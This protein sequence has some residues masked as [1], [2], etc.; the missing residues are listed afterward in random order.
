M[1]SVIVLGVLITLAIILLVLLLLA[2]A[3]LWW[4]HKRSQLQFIEPPSDDN[5]SISGSLRLVLDNK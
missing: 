1:V 2:G 3:Y 5:E 4:R